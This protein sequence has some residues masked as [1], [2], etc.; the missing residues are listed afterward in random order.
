[1]DIDFN[2]KKELLD[3]IDLADEFHGE[4]RLGY[5]QYLA[6][7]QTFVHVDEAYLVNPLPL[8]TEN[9]WLPGWRF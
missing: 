5:L 8:G 1:L 7:G 3:F 4:L 6:K 2:S 9:V